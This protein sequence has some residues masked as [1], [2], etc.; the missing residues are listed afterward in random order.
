MEYTTEIVDAG[1]TYSGFYDRAFVEQKDKYS[2]FLS[3]NNS[4]VNV[5]SLPLLMETIIPQM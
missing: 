2:S 5:R 1:V 4:V 3:G